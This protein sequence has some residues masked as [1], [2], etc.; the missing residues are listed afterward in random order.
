MSKPLVVLSGS[1]SGTN[2]FL[3]V[4][5]EMVPDAVVLREVFRKGGDNLPELAEL[6]GMPMTRLAVLGQEEPVAL[7]KILRQAVG[8]RPLALKIF[9][10][11]ARPESPIW[12]R[13]A[14]EARIVHLLRRRILDTLI[15]RK[16]AEATG[17]W[18]TP[19]DVTSPSRPSF[20]LDPAEVAAFIAARQ[21]YVRSFRERFRGADIHE[22]GY[23]DIAGDPHLCAT[24]IA[25]L[26]GAAI[27]D[28]P[29]ELP[30]RK[31]NTW[32]IPAVVSNY[33]EIAAFDKS[34]L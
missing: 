3:S 19:S 31:Q 34:H 18:I 15:S 30:I 23:E 9:Y 6:T 4:Y 12:E 7:W 27:P 22:I 13:F 26:T 25:R 14:K 8:S 33:D 28:L 1:R 21:D 24:E 32:T 10:Y 16:F 17:R 2:Y 20:R 29:L 11:H 5:K